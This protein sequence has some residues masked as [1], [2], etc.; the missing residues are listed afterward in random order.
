MFEHCKNLIICYVVQE[1]DIMAVRVNGFSEDIKNIGS[2]FPKSS[3]SK[4]VSLIISK[5]ANQQ[6]SSFSKRIKEIKDSPGLEWNE[7]TKSLLT[8]L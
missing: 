2:L 6:L 5:V 7:I 4:S 8:N 3:D 1:N